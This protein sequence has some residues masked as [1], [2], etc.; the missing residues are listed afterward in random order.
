MATKAGYLFDERP[1]IVR[2]TRKVGRR[3]VAAVRPGSVPSG[4][5][6]ATQDFRPAAMRQAIDAS[7]R[8]LATDHID[9]LQ[10]HGPHQHL[11][12]VFEE[13]TDVVAAGKVRRFGVGAESIAEAELWVGTP[14]LEVLQLPFGLLD[15]T[16]SAV[17]A[18]LDG[19]AG[20]ARGIFGGGVLAGR[21]RGT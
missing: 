12:R 7:L 21:R 15:P 18:R 10:L 13:L 8:R 5:T 19:T 11:P 14:G 20:W 1:P 4:D 16:A 6:Y 9:V 2:A 17:L 3:L